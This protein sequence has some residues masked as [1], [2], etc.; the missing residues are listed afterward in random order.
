MKKFYTAI[1][2]FFLL[3]P[4]LAQQQTATELR[5]TAKT[6]LQQG[7][8]DNAI[9]ALERARQQEPG[10]IDVLK[11]LSYAA[12]IKKDYA[13]A[14]EVGKEA[15][16]SIQA[17]AQAFQILGLSYKAIAMYKEGEKL[18]RTAL[19]KFPNDGPLHNEYGELLALDGKADEAIAQWEK[20]IK[21]DPSFS[22][23][24]YNAA[25]YYVQTK[26]WL[27]VAIYGELFVNLESYTKRT[28]AIKAQVL[29]A[30]SKILAPGYIAFAQSSKMTSEFEK[31]ILA[32]LDHS[33]GLAKDGINLE[34]ISSIRTRFIA[35]WLSEKDKKY[36][37]RLFSHHQQLTS[38]GYFEA[39]NQ[40]LLGE[41]ANADAYQAWQ[42]NHPKESEGLRTF[43]QG[44]VFK[45][46]A[47]Q[48]YFIR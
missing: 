13:R 37:F 45:I 35:E 9:K 48:Y 27:R 21:A 1:L 43:Q 25:Q 41:P 5:A 2:A 38:L 3:T 23:N 17:D 7:E 16:A 46:P 15:V 6:L 39:Y 47:D 33:S 32:V 18:Y 10:N 42:R 12:Y 20:G 14:R 34:N 22:S 19:S 11:E 31:D 30:W 8:L 44:R 24:Y 28:E 26:N 4:A 36:P 40:W 29:T